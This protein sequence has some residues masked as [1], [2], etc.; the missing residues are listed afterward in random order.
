[1]VKSR[2]HLICGVNEG[3]RG[4]GVADTSG[5]W[6][7]FDVDFCRAVAAAV[8]GD[9]SKVDY[10]PLSAD[11]RFEA[12][13]SGGV[14]LLARNSTWTMSRELEFGLTFVGTTYYDGQGFMVK[15]SA[16]VDTALELTG[17]KVCV[18]SGTTTQANLADF[19]TANHMDYTAVVTKSADESITAYSDN[20]CNVVTSDS[21]QLYAIRAKLA[22]PDE[23]I[24][25][26]ELISKE[27]LGPVVRQDDPKWAT[28]VKWVHFAL[29]GAEEL[30]V[31]SGTI[32]EA[33]SSQKPAVRRLVGLE[34]NL[35]EEL[36]LDKQWVVRMVR[37]VG[38]YGEIFDRNL[39]S[40]AA[41][42]IP[43]G[44]NQLWS[45]GGIQY[46]PTLQ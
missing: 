9:A 16:N 29:L 27:P 36:G 37:A 33:L 21:S 15:R 6:T 39:G 8:L 20:R 46:A 45:S 12:V 13:K 5:K 41:L 34:G 2:G 17:S 24:I 4:F 40:D 7:G 35:G 18:Q 26:P 38:N 1:M 25:L 19:F 32:D 11:A 42:G 43:R 28:L 44:I 23:H 22:N 10:V 14:D 31:A 3:L 30:G